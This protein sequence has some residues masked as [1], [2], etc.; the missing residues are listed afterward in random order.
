M[1]SEVK[2]PD[3]VTLDGLEDNWSQIWLQNKTYAFDR[4]KERS[5]VY[6]IDTPPP[7][8][9]GSLHV[10]HVFSYTQT[11]I[12]A[13]F[14]RMQGKAVFYPMGFDDNGLPTERRAQQY[15]GIRC[16]PSIP[17]NPNFIPPKIAGQPNS[18]AKSKSDEKTSGDNSP[19]PCSRPNFVELCRQL[20]EEDEKLFYDLFVRLGIS[21]DWS[22][23][24]TTI[25]EK[26]QKTSQAAFLQLVENGYAYRKEAPTLWDVDF[27]S[28]I[29]QAEIED[30]EV[31]GAYHKLKFI[32]SDDGSII[33]I[34]TTRPELLPACVALVC[35]P[36]DERYANLIG[37]T[38]TTPLFHIEVPIY[39]HE[40][41]D[42]D[43]GTG[44]AMV[45]TFG[46]TTDVIWWN[47]LKL[48]TRVIINKNGSLEP[49]DFSD[50]NFA[51]L[52]PDKA[53]EHYSEILGLNIKSAQKKIV[54]LLRNSGE[55]LGEPETIKHMVK[56]YEKGERPLEIISSNQW[57][58]RTLDKKDI[59]IEAGR[60]IN[61]HPDFM[62]LRFETW[63]EGLNSDW[64]ISRQRYFGVPFPVWYRLDQ[65]GGV[66]ENQPI[67]AD[68]ED[69]PLDPSVTPP[70]GYDE[71]M[72]GQK[73]GFVAD[74]DI[75]DTWATSS[76]TPQIAG[77]WV[78]ES[79]LF[80]RVFPMDLRPQAHEIIRTW[81]F[82]TVV[83][84]V[85]HHKSIPFKNTAI[86]GWILDKDHKKLS[87]SKGNA[88]VPTEYL[89]RHGTDAVR[90]WAS[91]ARLGMDTAFDEQQMKIGRRLSIKILNATKFIL[92]RINSP[93]LQNFDMTQQ[94]TYT[95]IDQ[96]IHYALTDLIEET[97]KSFEE[98]DHAKALDT[99]E[100]FFWY[101]CDDYLELS[102][103]R[104]YDVSNPS[105]SLSAIKT[106]EIALSVLL[107]LF[108]PFLPFVTEEV[109]SWW[110]KTSIHTSNWPTISEI[111][112]DSITNSSIHD[113]TENAKKLIGIT[114]EVLE[115]I[116]KKKS[117]EKL[118][119]RAQVEEVII[120]GPYQMI[121]LIKLSQDDLVAAGN[122]KKIT[123]HETETE[124]L[125]TEVILASDHTVI[126]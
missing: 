6:S 68:K 18:L 44:I 9:S 81:L 103:I 51:S 1:H 47:D 124:R 82:S 32:S 61:W 66:V 73:N 89:E 99:T 16:E 98:Y 48:K 4:T 105:S 109:W 13:R 34:A 50:K 108:A 23:L 2:V 111:V 31:A 101:F 8:V 80:D 17:Y 62:R 95:P 125:S 96:A 7:T 54:E 72:R 90:Y 42:K 79:G 58:I 123:Y 69:L 26:A 74:S 20:T 60:Q 102:K 56:F 11:D 25:G 3:K 85:A 39:G 53:R 83:R 97:T 106:L 35:N 28:A 30:R 46:D 113:D 33:P 71:T 59:L 120:S 10:G 115:K 41:A 52:E 107:R 126:Q 22:L 70:P 75:M 118:S 12:I 29:A 112:D 43:K 5:E 14:W 114:S 24:Y 45:C 40:L 65:E 87:K 63:T 84:S 55:L 93:E 57:Y 37:K 36:S 122:V 19:I 86:S 88:V 78:N 121:A 119:M 27:C 117:E 15:Y 64:N 110:H 94:T 92:T 49:I 38:A 67:F 104:T 77:D 91:A 76:L 21:V 100:R 116:R